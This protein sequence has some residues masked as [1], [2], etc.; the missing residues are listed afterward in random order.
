M[1][2]IEYKYLTPPEKK[3]VQEYEKFF[4]MKATKFFRIDAYT[5]VVFTAENKYKRFI[6]VKNDQLYKIGKLKADYT[7]FDVVNCN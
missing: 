5:Q 4:S 2:K 7:P 3:L 1:L 6:L